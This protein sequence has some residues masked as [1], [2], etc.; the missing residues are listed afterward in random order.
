[1][2]NGGVCIDSSAFWEVVNKNEDHYIGPSKPCVWFSEITGSFDSRG[3]ERKKTKN[4]RSR[5]FKQ[6][7]PFPWLLAS[8]LSSRNYTDVR[9]HLSDYSSFP[10]YHPP[11]LKSNIWTS[12]KIKFDLNVLLHAPSLP[13]AT[14]INVEWVYFC[15]YQSKQ[16]K[17][18]STIL[19]TSI[20]RTR[21]ET[22]LS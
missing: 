8:L 15:G 18:R 9:K 5:R 19:Q 10:L 3:R 22:R 7:F 2:R 12:F 21:K 4:V 17:V 1:M 6:K 16:S 14:Q 13:S 11:P 20:L